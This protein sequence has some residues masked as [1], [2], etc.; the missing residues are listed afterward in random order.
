MGAWIDRKQ[1][2]NERWKGEW[3]GVGN[4][5]F[6]AT[7]TDRMARFIL[8]YADH[9]VDARIYRAEAFDIDMEHG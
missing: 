8:N 1:D 6:D 3:C 7:P 2:Y 5:T 4:I 9:P